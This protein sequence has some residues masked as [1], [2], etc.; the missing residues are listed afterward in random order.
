[1][2][3][4]HRAFFRVRLFQKPGSQK[5]FYRCGLNRCSLCNLTIKTK[6]CPVPSCSKSFQINSFL[7][8]NSHHVIYVISCK[9]CSLNCVGCTIRHLKIRVAEHIYNV[10][11]G[12]VQHSGVAKHFI[13]CHQGD[14]TS[15]QVYAIERVFK[16]TR[17]GNWRHKLL[18]REAFCF[19][20]P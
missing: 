5:G 16:P 7:N 6:K 9:T 17:G 3:C 12:Q 10:K 1:M 18:M 13:E 19:F 2:T 14:I 11:K 15:L 8:C 4:C 20:L